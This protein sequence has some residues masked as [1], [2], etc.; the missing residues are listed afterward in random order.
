MNDQDWTSLTPAFYPEG[1]L[2]IEGDAEPK[3]Y[4]AFSNI[5]IISEKIYFY[6]NNAFS[7]SL[8]SVFN[9]L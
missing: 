1:N 7:N 6:S 5:R 9:Q 2:N 8:K 4:V 3:H